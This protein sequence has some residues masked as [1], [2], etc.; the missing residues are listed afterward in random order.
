M[1]E[2]QSIATLLLLSWIINVEN[3]IRIQLYEE[4]TSNFLF[5]RIRVFVFG[6]K[7][8]GGFFS[9]LGLGEKE[10]FR[11]SNSS[12]GSFQSLGHIFHDTMIHPFPSQ[13]CANLHQH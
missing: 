5:R 4:S 13:Q 7:D 11:S 9:L 1:N 12:S 8:K 6:E 10:W 3:P 2:S